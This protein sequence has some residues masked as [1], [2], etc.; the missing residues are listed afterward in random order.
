[1]AVFKRK[2]GYLSVVKNGETVAR[3]QRSEPGS[4]LGHVAYEPWLLLYTSGRIERYGA[5]AEARNAAMKI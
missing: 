4:E 3:I 5:M 1:M 2:N